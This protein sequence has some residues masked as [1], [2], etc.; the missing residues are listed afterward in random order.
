M[1][2]EKTKK[3][4]LSVLIFLLVLLAAVASYFYTYTKFFQKQPVGTGSTNQAAQSKSS[5]ASTKGAINNKTGNSS[6]GSAT[7]NLGNCQQ[8]PENDFR[9][10]DGANP[11]RV[12]YASLLALTKKDATVCSLTGST[13]D[14]SGVTCEEK[15]TLLTIIATNG[16]CSKIGNKDLS[17]SCLANQQKNVA[18]CGQISDSA[19]KITCE[20][21]AGGDMA[22]CSVLPAAQ[23]D[24][25]NSSFLFVK[26]L[27]NKDVSLCGQI[28]L[29]VAGGRFENATCRVLLGQDR[30]KEWN[31][32]YAS[33]V[34]LQKYTNLTAK[35]KND[36]ALC[37]KIPDKTAGNKDL[38]ASCLAQFK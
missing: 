19:K 33:N 12:F 15:Y 32:F 11:G 3:I 26:A 21:I 30:Q 29:T 37:E 17:I 27:S 35:E 38:Y 22:K 31:D 24:S 14:S 1:E 7:T 36:V 13:K 20:A 4:Y 28:N 25:C 6:A 23:K 9:K 16:D 5:G 34:C 18:V 10:E 2:P 8:D